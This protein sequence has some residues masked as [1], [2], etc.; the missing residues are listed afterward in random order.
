MQRKISEFSLYRWRYGIGYLLLIAASIAV[1]FFAALYLPGGLREEERASA[2]TSGAL[3]YQH[4]EPYMVFNLPYHIVQRASFVLFDIST[5]SVKI[6]SLIFGFLAIVGMYFLVASWFRRNDAILTTLLAATLPAFVFAAQD[7]TPVIYSITVAIWLLV[8]ATYVS[9]RQRPTLFW[10]IVFFTL[11]ALN[12]YTPLGIYLNLAIVTTI[13][14]HP[15]IRFTARRLSANRVVTA[16][17]IALLVLVPLIYSISMHPRLALELIGLPTQIP[18][19]LTNVQQLTSIYLGVFDQTASVLLSPVLSLGVLMLALIGLYRFIKIKYTARSYVIW[20]WL[21][22]LLPV[23]ILNP[24]H[25]LMIFPIIVLMIAMG[26]GTLIKE[27]YK[28]FPRNPYARAAGLMPLTLIVIGIMAAGVLRYATGYH[29]VASTVY[30]FNNDLHLLDIAL[31]DTNSTSDKKTLV[32]VPADQKQFYSL[33]A[34]YDKRY[35]VTTSAPMSIGSTSVVITNQ[36]P[37]PAT[38][39]KEPTRVLTRSTNN[40]ADRFY[41]YAASTK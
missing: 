11:L 25:A 35:R 16:A 24:K 8:S 7:G 32:I 41:I 15:H 1:L 13:I 12:L 18:S 26:I 27:W 21:I 36:A 14:F 17:T 30:K 31:S 19:I 34:V 39:F 4:F 37:L 2:I 23:I 5:L 6:P 3:N 10:K 38:L 9:R 20:F 28:M 33:T 29:Y 40:D 22:T